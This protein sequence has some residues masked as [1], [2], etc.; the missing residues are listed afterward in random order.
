L[1]VGSVGGGGGGGGGGGPPPREYQPG[2]FPAGPV[3]R[4]DPTATT[5]K[6][7]TMGRD[8]ERRIA[9]TATPAATTTMHAAALAN[10]R[11]RYCQIHMSSSSLVTFPA[12]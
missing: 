12:C 9:I 10:N 11:G 2:D 6:T 8:G 5:T 4:A 3:F 1:G 7:A